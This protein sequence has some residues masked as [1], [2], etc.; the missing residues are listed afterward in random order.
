VHFWLHQSQLP[1]WQTGS[2]VAVGTVPEQARLGAGQVML[3]STGGLESKVLPSRG[4]GA[5]S[6][7]WTRF[8][9]AQAPQRTSSAAKQLGQKAETGGRDSARSTTDDSLIPSDV[10][11]PDMRRCN[12]DH[13]TR[14][15]AKSRLL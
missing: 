10:F 2:Q 11:G 1:V 8:A 9:C 5:A 12:P 15:D 14:G 3:A 7:T 13:P 6:V 4:S